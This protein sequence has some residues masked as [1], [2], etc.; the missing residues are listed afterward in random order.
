M[1]LSKAK[2]QTYHTTDVTTCRRLVNSGFGLLD[3]RLRFKPQV[4]QLQQI[5][6]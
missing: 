1:P 2:L 6:I 3:M 5:E 4:R